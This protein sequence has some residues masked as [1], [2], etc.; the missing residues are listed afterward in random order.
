M[1]YTEAVINE[2]LR[3]SSNLP[4]GV[5]HAAVEDTTIG[6]F[7]VPKDTIIFSNLYAI[8][9]CEETWGDPYEFRPERFLTPDES[10]LIKH[11]TFVAFGLG[12]RM[13]PG[14]VKLN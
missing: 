10:T 14:I 12:K 4:F 8:H 5:P 3:K 11:E 13:C 9:H 2:T 6:S 7:D 1:T